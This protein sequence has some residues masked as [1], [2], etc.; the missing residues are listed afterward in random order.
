MNGERET[1]SLGRDQRRAGRGTA[2]WGAV[3]LVVGASAPAQADDT[4]LFV[5]TSSSPSVGA[6]PNVLFVLDTSGSMLADVLT[7]APW[8][9]AVAWE[10]CF[11]GDGVYFST[12]STRPSCDSNDWFEEAWNACQDSWG[13]LSGVGAYS[14]RLKA[15][16]EGRERWVDLNGE[17]KSRSV[18]CE[19]DAGVHG[20]GGDLLWAANGP[21]G[22]WQDGPDLQPAWNQQYYLWDG[23]WLNWSTAGG[24]V[25]RQRLDIVK[26]VAKQLLDNVDGVNVGLMRFNFEEGGPVLKA[27]ADVATNRAELEAAI[28]ALPAS[29]WTPLS[30]TLYEAGQY[31]AGRQVVYGDVEEPRSDPASRVGGVPDADAYASPATAACQKNYIVILTDGAPS[32]DTGAQSH[33]ESLPGF[34]TLIGPSCDGGTEDGACLDDMAEYLHKRDLDTTLPGLQNVTTHTIG[35]AVDLPLLRSTAERGGGDYFTADDTSSLAGALTEIML[36]ILDDSATFTA[37]SVPVNVFN[38]T[39]NLGD[40]YVSVFEPTGTMHWPGNLKKYGISGGRLVGRDGRPAVDPATGFFHEDAHSFWSPEPD[41]DRAAAGGAASRLP[42]AGSRRL[43]TDIA[44]APLSAAGNA[45]TVANGSLTAE[46]IG[47]PAGERDRVID[48]FRG[49]DV[50]DDDDD[51]SV[52]DTRRQ[53]GDPLH[54]RP[55]TVVYGGTAAAPDAVVF[56]ATNDGQL[57]AVDA[58]TGVELWAYTPSR[59]LGRIYEL[60]LDDPTP[61]KRYGLDGEIRAH[62]LN[63]DGLP[64]IAG[65]ER[66]ILVFGMR[67]GGDSVFALDVTDRNAPVRLWEVNSNLPGFSDLGQTWSTPVVADVNIGGTRRPVALFAGGYD[68]GQDNP[69]YRTDTIGNAVF[70]VDA[71]TGARLWSA[72]NTDAEHQLVLARMRHSIPAPLTVLDLD[73]DGLADRMYVGDMG[74]RVWRFDI[75]NGASANALV[76]GGVLASL[77]AAHLPSPPPPSEVRRF[78][79]APDVV[80]VVSQG[81]YFLTIN[82]GS[83]FRAHPL[84]TT[85]R[86]EFFSIRDFRVNEVIDSDSYPTPLTR[87]ALV[88]VTNDA[89]PELALTDRGWRLRMVQSAGEKILNRSTT[90]QNSV[91][92]TSFTP[93]TSGDS[94]VAARGLNRLYQVDVRTGGAVTNLDGSIDGPDDPLT[95][96]DRYRSLRQ[97]GI[98]PEVIFLFPEDAPDVPVACIGAE[99]LTPEIDSRLIRTYWTQDGV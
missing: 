10:G 79:A 76:E 18:E 81:R 61:T 48:W 35:F 11:R 21:S 68:E 77:G 45:I 99:C 24:T 62:V 47:A 43:Y 8:D 64:G 9:P 54:V 58:D 1:M 98:A 34:A 20:D 28:D 36:S 80:P 29:G 96:S 23:N 73:R 97:G 15:W 87:A 7:Q 19:N 65:E 51:G 13:P 56:T 30:E 70:M 59:L 31:F 66:V 57:H 86:D 67:R 91:F 90:F 85:T 27:L 52:T 55:V 63:D 39:Q 3:A 74:G 72:G 22:P 5:A 49:L 17:Q 6:Q 83:G 93:G 75:V 33:I 26:E 84:D 25:T 37:P 14:G 32:R 82:L 16:R 69:G 94:C 89:N 46:M 2:F 71:L 95:E 88:D 12:T 38:R 60:Y 44:G 53:M 40:V 4:E 41:G 42:D 78:Y 50:L 92:F